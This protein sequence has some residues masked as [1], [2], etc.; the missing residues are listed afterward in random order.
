MTADIK[1]EYPSEERRQYLD[2][3]QSAIARMSSASAVAKGWALTV[4]V[5]TY[6]Y[7]GTKH[8][9]TV[10]LL[11]V[12]ALLMFATVDAR[13]L[14][15]ERKYRLLFDAARKGEV[16]VYEMNATEY[17]HTLTSAQCDPISWSRVVWSWSV[18]DYYGLILLAGV[19]ILLWLRCA[20]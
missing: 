11:G 6:G 8:S 7:A 18:R 13:Y 15:E 9:V 20:F 5:A 10:A 17:C 14:R 1:P 19:A 3:I 16:D 12:F 4:A 2:F